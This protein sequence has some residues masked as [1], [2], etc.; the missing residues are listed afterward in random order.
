MY[1]DEQAARPTCVMCVPVLKDH[2]SFFIINVYSVMIADILKYSLHHRDKFSLTKRKLCK[3]SFLICFAVFLSAKVFRHDATFR[4]S[5][6]D[7]IR[8]FC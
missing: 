6:D 1:L 3:V 4:R 8:G 5:V 7:D 2:L